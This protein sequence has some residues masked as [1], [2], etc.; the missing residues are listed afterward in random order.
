M[1]L[2][3]Q[4]KVEMKLALKRAASDS[5]RGIKMYRASGMGYKTSNI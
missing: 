2:G 4:H 5:P 1:S 3:L